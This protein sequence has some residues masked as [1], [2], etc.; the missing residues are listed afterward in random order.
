MVLNMPLATFQFVE[1]IFVKLK[2]I[3]LQLELIIVRFVNFK[4]IL[5]LTFI[6][7]LTN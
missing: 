1:K 7:D 6:E 4:H 2:G 3:V 5:C